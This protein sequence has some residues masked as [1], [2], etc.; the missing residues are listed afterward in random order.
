MNSTKATLIGMGL[1]LLFSML[2]FNLLVVGV[3]VQVAK[4]TV[5]ET[6]TLNDVKYIAVQNDEDSLV[7]LIKNDHLT[8]GQKLYLEQRINVLCLFE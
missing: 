4:Y 6:P 8:V 5:I 2:V 1:G 3:P 7:T